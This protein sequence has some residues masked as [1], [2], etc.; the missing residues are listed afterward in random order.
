MTFPLCAL[1]LQSAGLKEKTLMSNIMV[2]SLKSFGFIFSSFV[3]VNMV[4]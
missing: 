4:N 3:T 2:L 1:I